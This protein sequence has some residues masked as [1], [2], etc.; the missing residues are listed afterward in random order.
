MEKEKTFFQINLFLDVKRGSFNN[1]VLQYFNNGTWKDIE[2]TQKEQNA[3]VISHRFEVIKSA[4]VRLL[5]TEGLADGYARIHEME[6]LGFDIIQLQNKTKTSEIKISAADLLLSTIDENTIDEKSQGIIKN[7]QWQGVNSAADLAGVLAIPEDGWKKI[8][9]GSALTASGFSNSYIWYRTKI[10]VPKELENDDL[11]L[12]LGQISLYDETYINKNLIGITGKPPPQKPTDGISYVV[13]RYVI[14][15]NSVKFGEMNDLYVKVYPGFLRGMYNGPYYLISTKNLK[16]GTDYSLRIQNTVDN[17]ALA[18]YITKTAYLNSYNVDESVK[19]LFRIWDVTDDNQK[20]ICDY[21]VADENEQ[22]VLLSGTKDIGLIEK[23]T[24]Y[25]AYNL[26]NLGKF[27]KGSFMLQLQFKSI[28]GKNIWK[29]EILFRIK[30]NSKQKVFT[31]DTKLQTMIFPERIYAVDKLSHGH[32]GFL[33]ENNEIQY[34]VRT[35]YAGGN[36]L[37]ALSSLINYKNLGPLLYRVDLCAMPQNPL[38]PEN[39]YLSPWG[40]LGSI[41]SFGYITPSR[42]ETIDSVEVRDVNWINIRY[43]I[44]YSDST[45][46][47]VYENAIHPGFFVNTSSSE[48]NLFCGIKEFGLSQP[49]NMC[50]FSKTAVIKTTQ[51]EKISDMQRNWLLVWFNGAAGWLN[52]DYPFLIVFQKKPTLVENKN[53]ALSVSFRSSGGWIAVLPLYGTVPIRPELTKEWKTN[54][55]SA[56]VSR[57]DELSALSLAIPI[58]C[59]EKFLINTNTDD[60]YVENTYGYTIIKDHWNTKPMK[61]AYVP[62]SFTLA[63]MNGFPLSL[64]H[65]TV[66]MDYA[67]LHGPFVY[68][69]DTERVIFSLKGIAKYINLHKIPDMDS[70]KS[71]ESV[72]YI[73]VINKYFDYL[74]KNKI[75]NAESIKTLCTSAAGDCTRFSMGNYLEEMGRGMMYINSKEVKKTVADTANQIVKDY[76]FDE[77][78]F[79]LIKDSRRNIEILMPAYN[80]RMQGIDMVHWMGKYF[81]GL[82]AYAYYF[83]DME[84]FKEKDNTLENSLLTLLITHDFE[85]ALCW[86]SLFGLREGSNMEDHITATYG[87]IAASRL[88]KLLGKKEMSEFLLY[89]SSKQLIGILANENVLSWVR[90]TVPVCNTTPQLERINYTD[91]A[92][93]KLGLEPNE[94]QGYYLYQIG[95]NCSPRKYDWFLIT[96]MFPQYVIYPFARDYFPDVVKWQFDKY[97]SPDTILETP[98]NSILQWQIIRS[99]EYRHH[100]LNES[101]EKLKKIYKPIKDKNCWWTV[102]VTECLLEHEGKFNN[103]R[104]IY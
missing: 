101:Y 91:L 2:D 94:Q 52:F 72:E 35:N 68:V 102:F 78:Y 33:F 57:C 104:L 83:N 5:V 53:D 92:F 62:A 30:D 75:M 16:R 42:E 58:T 64:S 27:S 71:P 47:S 36:G 95:Q 97:L 85:T 56:V 7:A 76:F 65:P 80:A 63:A 45:E 38:K 73:S 17:D 40:P 29:D 67:G 15:K 99:L 60:V 3:G 69:P 24:Y 43:I 48:I 81:L 32:F 93:E 89:V 34:I 46:L 25:S 84:I 22:K 90:D 8:S 23:N 28:N 18:H 39:C 9:I 31:V 10:L 13:R 87:L 61:A 86:D 98:S 26:I 51:S 103:Q 21:R 74:I 82:W 49:N 50:Y 79:T 11:A 96:L 88:Y 44:K 19:I 1:Y 14:P 66:N 41:W 20:Y 4:K 54:I 6:I 70:F 59:K 12:A 77:N 55:P 100:I 37:L